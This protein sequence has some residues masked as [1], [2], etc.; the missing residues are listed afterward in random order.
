MATEA[1]NVSAT[2][3]EIPYHKYFI[4]VVNECIKAFF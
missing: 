1:V 2:E 3:K 4:R